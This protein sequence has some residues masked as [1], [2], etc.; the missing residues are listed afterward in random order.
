[1]QESTER[2]QTK[3]KDPKDPPFCLWL[4]G[5]RKCHLSAFGGWGVGEE[6][7]RLNALGQLPQELS[8]PQSAC[9]GDGQH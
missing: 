4:L 3:L 7:G 2:R 1:M 9:L 5:T 8:I 6:G